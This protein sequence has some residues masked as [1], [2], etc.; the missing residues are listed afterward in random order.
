MCCF[1]NWLTDSFLLFIVVVFFLRL[2]ILQVDKPDKLRMLGILFFCVL[3]NQ[4][5]GWL[6]VD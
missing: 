3:C 5:V 6:L 1:M 2:A 4:L